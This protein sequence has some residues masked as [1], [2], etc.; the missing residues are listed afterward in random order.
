MRYNSRRV[1]CYRAS[2]ISAEAPVITKELAKSALGGAGVV[3]KHL[4]LGSEVTLISVIGNDSEA[5]FV[6]NQLTAMIA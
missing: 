3:A 1:C 6:Q 5:D 2:R 4:E